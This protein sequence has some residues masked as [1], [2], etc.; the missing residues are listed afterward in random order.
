[1]RF[2]ILDSALK[3]VLQQIWNENLY[4]ILSQVKK[5]LIE[6]SHFLDNYSE[7]VEIWRCNWSKGCQVDLE[8]A[9]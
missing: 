5:V 6:I 4:Y 9:A 8:A 7:V 2:S 1:M 3:P